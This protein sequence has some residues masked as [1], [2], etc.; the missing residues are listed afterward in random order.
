MIYFFLFRFFEDKS[1]R[2]GSGS[3]AAR[4]KEARGTCSTPGRGEVLTVIGEVLKPRKTRIMPLPDPGL[5]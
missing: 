1:P 5:P 4:L 3:S 2:P